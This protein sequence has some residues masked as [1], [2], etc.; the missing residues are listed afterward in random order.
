MRVIGH[1]IDGRGPGSFRGN[2]CRHENQIG[3]ERQKG[4]EPCRLDSAEDVESGD[5]G[6][7][8][9][10]Q[11]D[12]RVEPARMKCG[13]LSA[14]TRLLLG[15]TNTQI[16]ATTRQTM[17]QMVRGIPRRLMPGTFV[18]PYIYFC[19][20]KTTQSIPFRLSGESSHFTSPIASARF[21][22][23]SA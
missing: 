7:C 13:R 20:A 5:E 11:P 16:S 14:S 23:L 12:E 1:R 6:R 2:K 10:Q 9:E 15:Q 22:S 4:D 3:D 19:H 17:P 8:R 18:Q 21:R